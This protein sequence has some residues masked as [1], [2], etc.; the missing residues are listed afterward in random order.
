[1]SVKQNNKTAV[2]E[3][4]AVLPNMS[5]TYVDIDVEDNGTSATPPPNTTTQVCPAT[6]WPHI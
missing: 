1:M 2:K 3:E 4:E 5:V 6:V